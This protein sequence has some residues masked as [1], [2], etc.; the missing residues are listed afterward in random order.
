MKS[1]FC[2]YLKCFYC[3]YE[4]GLQEVRYRVYNSVKP[5]GSPYRWREVGHACEPC[6][7]SGKSCQ[8]E[9]VK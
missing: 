5:K 8:I 7:D 9:V 4:F 2:E 3:S 6:I 1:E